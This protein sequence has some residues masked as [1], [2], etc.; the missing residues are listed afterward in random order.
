MLFIVQRST[1]H[2]LQWVCV[3]TPK[4]ICRK[5]E[6]TEICSFLLSGDRFFFFFFTQ[7]ATTRGSGDE[8]P[9]AKPTP[10][11]EHMQSNVHLPAHVHPHHSG[12]RKWQSIAQCSWSSMCHHR[13]TLHCTTSPT[14][15]LKR[16]NLLPQRCRNTNMPRS[17]FTMA[18][19]RS[20]KVCWKMKKLAVIC[21]VESR[22]LQGS[23]SKIFDTKISK[24]TQITLEVCLSCWREGKPPFNSVNT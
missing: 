6:L 18:D 13:I 21:S 20:Q 3:D 17:Q 22:V 4:L 11:I 8:T 7:L 2:P 10:C 19:E 1:S 5:R 12:C 14:Q 23:L 16:F 9:K 24:I 15:R